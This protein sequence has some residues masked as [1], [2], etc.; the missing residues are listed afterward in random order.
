MDA[1]SPRVA[2]TGEPS[3]LSRKADYRGEPADKAIEAALEHGADRPAPD[4]VG[5]VAIEPVLA[6]VEIEGR[7]IGRTEIMQ[8]CEHLVEIEC[9]DRLPHQRVELRQPVQDPA[10]EFGHDV[11]GDFLGRGVAIESS[12]QVAQGVAQTAVGVALALEDLGPYPDVLGVIRA[13]DPETQNIRAA[14]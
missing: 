4:I 12:Q 9:V 14:L 5:R 11:D 2:M 13:H 1:S 8:R 6:N 10:I 7:Q 3:L